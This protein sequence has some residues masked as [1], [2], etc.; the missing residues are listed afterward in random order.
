[1]TQS[2]ATT[3][4]TMATSK[5]TSE[6][7][8]KTI[9]CAAYDAGVGSVSEIVFNAIGMNM[10]GFASKAPAAM[11]AIHGDDAM[12]P[13]LFTIPAT[14]VGSY[15]RRAV[16]ATQRSSRLPRATSRTATQVFGVDGVSEVATSP[17]TNAA[18]IPIASVAASAPA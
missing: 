6:T 13:I 16:R 5:G 18:A 4:R 1:M 2:R 15:G 11:T 12:P 14:L 17:K 10:P 3:S 9:H 7:T 8:E